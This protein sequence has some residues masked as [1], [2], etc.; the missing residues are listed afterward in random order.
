MSTASIIKMQRPV[1]SFSGLGGQPEDGGEELVKETQ[2]ERIT[3]EATTQLLLL[4]SRVEHL[5]QELQG[6][7]EQSYN[8]GFQDGLSAEC[9]KHSQELEAHAQ[10]FRDLAERLEKEFDQ[11]L[12]NMEEPLLRMGFHISEK[13][14]TVPLP[15]SIRQG[16]LAGTIQSFL[17]EVLH[18]GS[19]V[20]HVSPED[21]A[22][23][24]T[25]E[26]SEKLKQSFPGRIRFVADDSLAAGECLVETPEHIIDG[27]YRTRLAILE[28]KLL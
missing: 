22:I 20:I 14:L 1:F 4:Q 7:R 2:E 16:A 21:L 3:E 28:S 10:Q 23:M 8:L 18:E 26:M 6:A 25:E 13:I 24:Q 11:A 17:K 9:E 19:V 15:E 5:E 12:T 27:R